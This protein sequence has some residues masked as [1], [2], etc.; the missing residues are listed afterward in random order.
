MKI[1]VIPH[2]LTIVSPEEICDFFRLSYE[3]SGFRGEKDFYSTLGQCS[4]LLIELDSYEDM[5]KMRAAALKRDHRIAKIATSTEQKYFGPRCRSLTSLFEFV[6]QQDP[7][8]WIS[9]ATSQLAVQRSIEAANFRKV[10]D[11][12]QVAG[13]LHEQG[14]EG[15]YSV[16]EGAAIVRPELGKLP[17]V[18]E[19]G[20][21]QYDGVESCYNEQ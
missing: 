7:A 1:E 8:A 9:V 14:V 17:S 18:Y 4:S 13:L 20:I 16:T 21:W 6:G 5:L 11:P 3:K 2:D 15:C 19:Q 12:E 10:V